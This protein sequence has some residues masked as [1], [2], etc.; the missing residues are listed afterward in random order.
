MFGTQNTPSNGLA[1]THMTGE[2]SHLIEKKPTLTR[3]SSCRNCAIEQRKR[4]ITQDA[5]QRAFKMT[6]YLLG[7]IEEL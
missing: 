4:S 7:Q 3:S 5:F 6:Q 2:L 1:L